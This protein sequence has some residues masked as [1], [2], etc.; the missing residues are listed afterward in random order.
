MNPT[1]SSMLILDFRRDSLTSGDLVDRA[2]RF[3]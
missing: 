1:V 2:K 3:L